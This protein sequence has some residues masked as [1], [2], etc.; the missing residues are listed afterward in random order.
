M[1]L[2]N[3]ANNIW[4]NLIIF[5]M[6]I[7][8]VV[9]LPL[10]DKAVCRKLKL[11]LEHG[12]SENPKANSLLKLRQLVLYIILGIYLL[13]NFY[14]VF[15]SRGESSQ[16]QI[17]TN[18]MYDV[19]NSLHIDIGVFGMI[20]D[21]F[22]QGF[23]VGFSHIHIE[24]PE[25]ITQVLTNTM[26][27]IPMGYL[28]PYTIEKLRSEKRYTVLLCFGFSFMTENFQLIFKRGFYD[29]D[30]MFFNTLGGFIGFMLFI[31]FAYWLTR[32]NWKKEEKL[33]FNWSKRSYRKSLYLYRRS[34]RTYRIFLTASSEEE[35]YSYYIDKLGFRLRGLKF[36]LESQES[37]ML[38]S[39]G[40]VFIEINCRNESGEIYPQTISIKSK[41]I[42]KVRKKL[43]KNGIEVS[44]YQED[45]FTHR[46]TMRINA[47]DNVTIII[48]E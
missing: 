44:D 1:F 13:A 8:F 27:Y 29:L 42:E 33:R 18:F 24:R 28:L 16:Y 37:I 10:I 38:I 7:C 4:I 43:I 2:L 40:S 36:S 5:I 23:D 46:R 15:L 48:S 12:I 20:K 25:D 34:F 47:P 41:K 32:P 39:L 17:N 35:V 9:L 26:L 30:D 21:I 45:I 6:I 31:A 14:L 11:N 19:K 22:S 3:L